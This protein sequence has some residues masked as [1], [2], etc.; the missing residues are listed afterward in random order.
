MAVLLCALI[1]L[2]KE[3]PALV[4]LGLV[5]VILVVMIASEA[6]RYAEARE[7]VRHEEAGPEVHGTH[8]VGGAREGAPE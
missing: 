6:V 1:P 4:A 8:V 3:L 7:Q 5:T 2:A